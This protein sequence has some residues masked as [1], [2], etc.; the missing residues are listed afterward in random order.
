[1]NRGWNAASFVILDSTRKFSGD[2][3]STAFAALK[4]NALGSNA[5]AYR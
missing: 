2:R 1:M 5:L 3:Q 4:M